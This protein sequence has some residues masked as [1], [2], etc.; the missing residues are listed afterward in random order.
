MATP[1]FENPDDKLVDAVLV[2]DDGARFYC[3]RILLA[4]HAGHFRALFTNGMKETEMREFV[5]HDVAQPDMFLFLSAVY[6][7]VDLKGASS[8]AVDAIVRMAERFAADGILER[9]LDLA[10]ETFLSIPLLESLRVHRKKRYVELLVGYVERLSEGDYEGFDWPEYILK[11][12]VGLIRRPNVPAIDDDSL[13]KNLSGQ[14][15]DIVSKFANGAY[16]GPHE[17]LLLIVGSVMVENRNNSTL[18]ARCRVAQKQIYETHNNDANKRHRHQY[19]GNTPFDFVPPT[20]P[21]NLPPQD[22]P[23]LQLIRVASRPQSTY[24]LEDALATQT[25][26]FGVNTGGNASN[27]VMMDEP[28]PPG[29]S[30]MHLPWPTRR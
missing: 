21:F 13:P 20:G 29:P 23:M 15:L 27:T 14:I 12:Y 22:S 17:A 16:D 30:V 4:M 24:T 2:L 5:L 8:E 26:T 25:P 10:S 3:H 1:S 18:V 9:C 11:D 19:I 28:L 7:K 6:N